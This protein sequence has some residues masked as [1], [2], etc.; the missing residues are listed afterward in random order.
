MKVDV[1]F[2]RGEGF[3]PIY[4][5]IGSAGADLFF[6]IESLR[7]EKVNDFNKFTE[8]FINNTIKDR[9]IFI[10]SF[11][12]IVL[13]TG[14][15]LKIPV[16]YEGQVRSRSGKSAN[17]LILLNGVG[18]IDSDYRGEILLFFY[19]LSNE[20]I[21]IKSWERVAQIIFTKVKRA[22]FKRVDKFEKLGDFCRG[23]SGFGSTGY[24]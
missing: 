13:G 18:T 20:G 11:S 10:P 1:N 5:T 17:G 3:L 22:K 15:C 2:K 7:D 12:R 9:K 21:Y 14:V 6:D 8:E 4:K 24:F 16:N 19:N 23:D